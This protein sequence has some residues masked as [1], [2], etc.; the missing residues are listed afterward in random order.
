MLAIIY[1]FTLILYLVLIMYTY[2]SLQGFTKKQAIVLI[3]A[4]T[5]VIYLIT[6]IIYTIMYNGIQAEFGQLEQEVKSSKW[7]IINLFTPVNAII[8]LPYIYKTVSK[9][10]QNII[11]ANKLRNL[12]LIRLVLVII[13][14]IFEVNYMK[15]STSTIILQQLNASNMM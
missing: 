3:I 14:I 11:D 15:D 7:L 13:F 8:F 1:I 9:Y 4:G 12:I 5:A 6:M 10:K 2:H